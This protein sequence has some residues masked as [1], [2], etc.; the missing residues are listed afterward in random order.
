MRFHLGLRSKAKRFC[1]SSPAKEKAASGE[2]PAGELGFKSEP[3]A[4]SRFGYS[5]EFG[6]KDE[7]FFD[8][9]AWMDSDCEDDFYSVNGDLTPSRGSTPKHHFS[10][11]GTPQVNKSLQL[12]AFLD[13]EA[14]PS[15]TDGKK[16]LLDLLLETSQGEQVGEEQNAEI[17]GKENGYKLTD[18]KPPRSSE[19]SPHPS[20]TN[21]VR[22]SEVTPGRDFNNRKERICCFPGLMPSHNF[23]DRRK[24]KI[25][26]A[27]QTERG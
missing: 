18:N 10:T 12:S 21:S 3:V 26:P 22:S 4:D 24:P 8:S 15:P 16:K 6:S 27:R 23:N 2:S 7:I 11:S 17:N 14:E 19:G 9:K 25:S 5:S 1:L 13:S 20:G